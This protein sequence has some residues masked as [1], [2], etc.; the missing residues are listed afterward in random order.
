MIKNKSAQT[1]SNSSSM[2]TT[3]IS[4]LACTLLLISCGV[5]QADYDKLKEEN[6]K[7]K[8]QVE[9]CQL[10]ASELLESAQLDY[11][12]L[13][14]KRSKRLLENLLSKYPKSKEKRKAKKLLAKVEDALEATEKALE[15]DK[16][17]EESNNVLAQMRKRVDP[18]QGVTFYTDKSSPQ[19]KTISALHIYAGSKEKSK[20]WMGLAVNHFS[21]DGWLHIQKVMINADGKIFNIQSEKPDDFKAKKESGG[22]REWIDHVVTQEDMQMI[23]T[24]AS[25]DNVILTLIGKD[26][27]DKR[28]VTPAEKKAIQNVLEV[29]K[30]L[31]G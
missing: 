8:R 13:E 31:G 25:G 16:L 15:K 6:E 21:K 7:L 1:T 28:A 18:K 12:R 20:P 22:F 2:K 23:Q 27:S 9:E 29:Y 26:I 10:N 17:I 14:Y 19:D 4:F 5:P 3:I 11:E 24:I 30:I